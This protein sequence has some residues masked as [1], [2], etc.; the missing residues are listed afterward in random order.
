MAWAMF[1]T[2]LVAQDSPQVLWTQPVGAS[3][4]LAFSPDGLWLAGQNAGVRLW[5]VADGTP[6]DAIHGSFGGIMSLAFSPDGL[7]IAS[8]DG[9]GVV[10][11]Y[12]VWDHSLAWSRKVAGDVTGVIYGPNG[13]LASWSSDRSTIDLWRADDGAASGSFS[14]S[15]WSHYNV[16]FSPDGGLVALGG[17]TD[18]TVR[19]LSVPDGK[20]VRTLVGHTARV[21]TVVFSTDGAT[22]A[23]GGDDA[24]IR[25]WRV[26][27]G[28][29]LRVLAGHSGSVWK[30]A[31]A[32]N[33]TLASSGTDGTLRLWRMTDGVLLRT[34][35]TGL[36]GSYSLEFSPDGSRFAFENNEQVI[37]VRD[38]VPAII[39]PP[40]RLTRFAGQAAEFTVAATGDAP[41]I[42]QWRRN[43]L[44]LTGATNTSLML[45]NLEPAN[46]GDYSIE[47]SNS[48]GTVISRSV[49]LTVL[50]C[51]IGP[52]S[53]DVSFDPTG[54]GARPGFA[55][56]IAG[57]RAVVLAPDGRFLIGGQ[58]ASVNGTVRRHLARMGQD[59]SVD[60]SFHPGLGLDGEV[61]AM[62]R[63][64]DGEIVVAGLFTAADGQPH[65][66]LVRLDAGPIRPV[67]WSG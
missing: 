41:L 10:R 48:L 44:L 32:P 17:D 7:R 22:L 52:G 5:R 39:A 65:A 36:G 37:V 53:L 29:L 15:E 49:D 8:G 54:G 25:L 11:V 45:R 26:S 47:V 13:V 43:G 62:A 1:A 67:P 63:Q 18:P 31:V 20:V 55:G 38:P 51:P 19:L 9:D 3:T 28:L 66:Q 12:N 16:A 6:A 30:I 59:G 34:Y 27:D 24:V 46:G 4:P 50:T 61:T 40:S 42:Y 21:R 64:P 14:G 23:T 57:V 33:S 60:P 58:F 56:G 2:T 35:A